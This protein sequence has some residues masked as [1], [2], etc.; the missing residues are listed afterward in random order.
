MRTYSVAF[1]GFGN[2]AK[3]LVRLLET[4][5]M[6]LAVRYATAWRPTG[7]ATRSL[8]WW[9]NSDGLTLSN[10]QG[11]ATRCYDVGDWLVTARPDVVFET[12]ALDPHTGQPALDYLDEALRTGAHAVSA[13]NTP[14]SCGSVSWRS[15]W[16]V[17]SPPFST[18]VGTPGS[19]VR[20]PNE[21]PPP[22]NSNAVT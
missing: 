17:Q 4:R 14:A 20:L 21:P 19:G 8:G 13:K 9:A 2:V 7:V 10:P 3:A 16:S 15:R 5:R 6:E 1:L 11:S 12:I 18:L 22:A